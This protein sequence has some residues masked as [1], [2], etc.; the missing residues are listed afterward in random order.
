MKIIKHHS[1]ILTL[2]I[3]LLGVL[4]GLLFGWIYAGWRVE[5]IAEE[6]RRTNP[7]DPLDGLFFVSI[8]IIWKGLLTGT[9]AGI[10]V[11][12]ISYFFVG[13]TRNLV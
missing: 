3:V 11:G 4:L 9:S 8:G 10:I 5:A 1:L 7:N 2:V 12:T 6:L 13:R